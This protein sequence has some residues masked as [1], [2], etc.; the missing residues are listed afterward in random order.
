MAHSELFGLLSL[1]DGKS[2][3]VCEVICSKGSAL[4]YYFTRCYCDFCGTFS[5]PW[6]K[7]EMLK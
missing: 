7:G 4:E 1:G 2:S 3:L 5:Y 6:I